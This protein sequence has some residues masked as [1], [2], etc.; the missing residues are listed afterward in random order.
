VAYLV[1]VR[2]FDRYLPVP[3]DSVRDSVTYEGTAQSSIR[4]KN[5]N[6]TDEKRPAIEG[7]SRCHAYA[8]GQEDDG[9]FDL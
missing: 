9:G 4:D 3:G 5:E 7:M 8:G 1:L 6:V 2:R